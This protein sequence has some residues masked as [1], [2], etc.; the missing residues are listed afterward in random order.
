MNID[1][2]KIIT[3]DLKTQITE[4][5][6]AEIK[7]EALNERKFIK[8]HG[9]T[10]YVKEH[11]SNKAEEIA[12]LRVNNQDKTNV[13]KALLAAN[14]VFDDEKFAEMLLNG[15][16]TYDLLVSYLKLLNYLKVRKIN[17]TTNENDEKYQLLVK[18]FTIKLSKQISKYIGATNPNI[19]IN[20]INEVVSF[21]P[22]LLIE[23]T[24][25]YTR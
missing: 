6:L 8:R 24:N 10:A 4:E 21:K 22:I 16:F 12:Y 25:K 17:G 14:I 7:L 20:K 2:N 1:F 13:E 3:T 19:I 5:R 18:K 15:D 11:L 9:I 23:E